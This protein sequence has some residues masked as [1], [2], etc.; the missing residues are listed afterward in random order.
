MAAEDEE[1]YNKQN[2]QSEEEN[3]Q[4]CFENLY[5]GKWLPLEKCPHMFHTEC[6][7]ESFKINVSLC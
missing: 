7:K 4:I 2:S 5:E 6:M 1:I 3:C